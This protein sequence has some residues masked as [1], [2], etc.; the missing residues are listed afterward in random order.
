[1]PLDILTS[2]LWENCG[3]FGCLGYFNPLMRQDFGFL[4]DN[5][6]MTYTSGPLMAL[7]FSLYS[8]WHSW[9]SW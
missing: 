5:A 8:V 7:H 6:T 1:M 2:N 4:G 3:T 9:S